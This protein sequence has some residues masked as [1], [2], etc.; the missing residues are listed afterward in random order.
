M[1]ANNATLCNS[2]KEKKHLPASF[3][4][5]PL[6]VMLCS[7]H[8]TSSNTKPC[9]FASQRSSLDC[10]SGLLGVYRDEVYMSQFRRIIPLYTEWVNV[11]YKKCVCVVFRVVEPIRTQKT[12]H[13]KPCV[14]AGKVDIFLFDC[15]SIETNIRTKRIEQQQHYVRWSFLLVYSPAK[16]ELCA[17]I[18]DRRSMKYGPRRNNI[19]F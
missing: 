9:V 16:I 1:R 10:W 14:C 4:Y 15:V 18:Y 8:K 6:I 13:K 3:K 11:M 2:S 17:S 19:W 7:T 12:N 5:D